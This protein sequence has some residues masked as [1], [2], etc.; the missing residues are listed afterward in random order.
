MKKPR[1]LPIGTPFDNGGWKNNWTSEN[2]TG[3]ALGMAG[4]ATSILGS[5]YQMATPDTDSV[6]NKVETEL[7]AMKGQKNIGKF[8]SLDDLMAGWAANKRLDANYNSDDYYNGPNTGDIITGT[9]SSTIQGASAG[10]M[11]GPWGALA[12]AVVGLG[13]GLAGGLI[14]KSKAQEA[15]DRAAGKLSSEAMRVNNYRQMAFQTMA[16]NMSTKN[17][18]NMFASMAAYGGPIGIS[19]LPVNGAIDFM[20]NEELLALTGEDKTKNN[21]TR[22]SMPVFA[23]GGA[24]GGY[25]GDWSNG[26]NFIKAG[27]THGQNPIGGVPMGVAQDGMPNLVEEG[28]VVWNDYVFSN[29]LNVPKE[30]MERL[31]IKGKDTMT[32]AEA[33]EKAQKSSAERPNDPI[34]KRSLEAALTNLM[35]VQE[36]IR[37]EKAER[38]Q[39][40]E[41]EDMAAFAADG[42]PI[43]IAKNKKGTFTAAATKHGMGVQEFASHVLAN[44]DK[45]SSAMVKKANFARNASK[46]HHA[47]GG[48]LFWPGGPTNPPYGTRLYGNYKNGH[49]FISTSPMD[50]YIPTYENYSVQEMFNPWDTYGTALFAPPRAQRTLSNEAKANVKPYTQ[51]S[52]KQN[53]TPIYLSDDSEMNRYIAATNPMVVSN[54]VPTRNTVINSSNPSTNKGGISDL[55]TSGLQTYLR[56]APA[57]GSALLL[58]HTLAN[59]PDYSYANELE[60]AANQYVSSLNTN[61]T[62]KFLGDYLAYRPFDRLFYANELGAQ[63]AAERAAIMQASNGN[64]GAAMAGLLASGYNRNVGLGKLFREG[65]EYNLAQRQ[66]VAEF[67]RA[68]NQY[69][70]QADLTAQQA[71][72][73]L[74]AAKAEMLLNNKY[75]TTAMKQAIDDAR[76]NTIAAN[77]SGLFDSLGGIGTEAQQKYWMNGLINS[78]WAYTPSEDMLA[79]WGYPRACGGKMNRRKKKGITI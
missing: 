7:E 66:K 12:G 60:E 22:T 37:Q 29:R 40:N 14:G 23:F 20:Q 6:E 58:G 8:N 36:G 44:K 73:R 16:Q 45:F 62:P 43:H 68:T 65:E 77:L 46:W 59:K 69:N 28:E 24:L 53:P 55:P 30:A 26:L 34:E 75:R 10:S 51:E 32:F 19:L 9:L 74:N 35:Q 48:H 13:S 25:G 79:A 15:A 71:N 64:A 70:S 27:G 47:L 54:N 4:A 3:S 67:N 17:D 78:G 41:M 52:I 31:G 76:A 2:A 61:I 39:F 21:N 49:S 72:A 50:A 18:R 57:L 1:Y 38:D 56:Y 5:A 11:A 42:G 63:E 33:V